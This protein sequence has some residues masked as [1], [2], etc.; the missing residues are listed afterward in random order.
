MFFKNLDSKHHSPIFALRKTEEV[1]LE[2]FQGLN[3]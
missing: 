2:S 3:W 1:S